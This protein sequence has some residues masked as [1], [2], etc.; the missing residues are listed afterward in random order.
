MTITDMQ[1]V[2]LGQHTF[3]HTMRRRDY[4]IISSQIE[5][6]NGKR[7]QR[8]IGTMLLCSQRHLLNKGCMNLFPWN[9]KFITYLFFATNVYISA[10]G[11]TS[12]IALTTLSEPPTVTSHSCTIATFIKIL[13]IIYLPL[14]NLS[15]WEIYFSKHKKIRDITLYQPQSMK[16]MQNLQYPIFQKRMVLR[17]ATTNHASNK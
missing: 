10:S 5:L 17:T 7:K 14:A 3:R 11:N 6:L 9:T 16:Y 4:N 13:L 15:P 12:R 2:S 8:K 1:L